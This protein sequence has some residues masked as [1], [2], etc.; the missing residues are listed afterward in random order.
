MLRGGGGRKGSGRG[1][2]EKAKQAVRDE[3]GKI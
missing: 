1:G 3:K 2:G